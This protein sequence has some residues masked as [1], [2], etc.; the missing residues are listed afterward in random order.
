VPQ[1]LAVLRCT[2]PDPHSMALFGHFSRPAAGLDLRFRQAGRT[3]VHGVMG[4]GIRNYRR[5]LKGSAESRTSHI[6]PFAVS[7]LPS[8]VKECAEIDSGA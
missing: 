4:K 7:C 8:G 2:L 5:Q 3:V 1:D 6:T